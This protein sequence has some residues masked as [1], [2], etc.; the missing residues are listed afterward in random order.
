[1]KKLKFNQLLALASTISMIAGSQAVYAQQ[2]TDPDEII[3]TGFKASLEKAA[4]I[5]KDTVGIVDLVTSEDIGKLPDKSIAESLMRLP[6]LATQRVNGRAQVISIRGFAPEFSTTLLNGRQ[7]ASTNENRAVE[8]DQYPAEFT[9]AAVVYKTP[10]A[11]LLA[12]GVAG[13]IDIQTVKPLAYGKQAII[14]SVRYEENEKASL[15]SD[16]SN[17]GYRGSISYIDQFNDNTLGLALAFSGTNSPTQGEKFNAWDYK[18]QYRVNGTTDGLT[19]DATTN[20]IANEFL[21]DIPGGAKPFVQSDVV[22]RN[23]VMGTLEFEP[24]ENLHSTV[25]LFYSKFK[26]TQTLRGIELPLGWSSANLEPGFTVNDHL[27]TKGTFT[28]VKGVIRNDAT[29]ADSTVYAIGWNTKF[30]MGESWK[31]DVDIS[32]SSAERD[33]EVLENYS[34][35]VGATDTISFESGSTGMKYKNALDYTDASK[36]RITNL[37]SWSDGFI[38]NESGGQKGFDSFGNVKDTLDQI[39]LSANRDIDFP[40]I[41]NVEVGIAHDKRTKKGDGTRQFFID[42]ATGAV[43]GPLPSNTG[44]A[45]LGFL[46]LGS[47]ISY[48]PLAP[49]NQGLYKLVPDTRSSTLKN[50]WTVDETINTAYVKLG[51]ETSLADMPITGDVG[52]QYVGTDQS[53]DGFSASGE[54]KQGN[55]TLHLVPD[56]GGTTF[57]NVLP[58]LNLKLAITEQDLVKFGLA[59]S[60]TRPGMTQMR[61]TNSYNLSSKADELESNSIDHSPWSA[62][63]GNPTLKPWLSDSAD[64]SFEHYFDDSKGYFSVASFYKELASYIYN[65]TTVKDFTGYYVDPAT[66]AAYPNLARLGLNNVPQ[67]GSG[68]IVKG[69]E[70]T[71]SVT[72]DMLADALSGFGAVLTS[73]YTDS[74]ITPP[75]TKSKKLP[76]LSKNVHGAQVYYE[77]GGFSVRISENYRSSFLGDFSSNI[78]D[79]VQRVVNATTLLD[80]QIGYAFDSGALDGLSLSLQGYNLNDEPTVSADKGDQARVIDYQSYGRTFALSATYKF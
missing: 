31:G 72:G 56:H 80:A 24:S 46:G 37:Q 69:L 54:I 14:G 42:L 9:S 25:D 76:G 79:P 75:D 3:V 53:S 40:V 23:S 21:Y 47:I 32:R 43:S 68:G 35:Y 60:L 48:D 16:V 13:T 45:N 64:L 58:S 30:A 71:V 49:K 10:S 66:A 28:N 63:G 59:R 73:S 26:E 41:S 33:T 78:G 17:K 6:G 5:K 70:F 62:S 1:M 74:N 7:Q 50:L 36:V 12:Q 38:P 29:I 2:A 61:V 67:N 55:N 44:T 27:V 8:Y 77:Q 39:R 57:N 20:G 52:V 18:P 65:K 51:I 22:D 34:G 15:N 4:E 19:S 11:S